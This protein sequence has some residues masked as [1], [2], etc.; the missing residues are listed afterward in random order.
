[1]I[2][3]EWTQADAMA[4][5]DPFFDQLD[6]ICRGGVA[7]Y[8]EYPPELLIE[9]DSRTTANCIYSHM[10]TLAGAHLTD[11][12]G[13]V[14][15]VIRGLKVWIIGDRATIRF[16]RM[17]EDGRSRNYPT[18]QARDFD[19]QLPLPGFPLPPLNLVV[20]Y[21]PDPTGTVV[22]RVQVAKPA[23]KTIDWCAAIVPT[24]D[25]IVGQPRWI[26]VTRQAR[27]F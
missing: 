25:R 23:G 12:P 19:R 10:V 4:E 13:I 21:L 6:L 11:Q 5:L 17:D 15:K 1:M 16:K 9:H 3:T 2:M 22:E 8:R 18:K 7:R 20:G 27:A 14:H 24:S 26:D